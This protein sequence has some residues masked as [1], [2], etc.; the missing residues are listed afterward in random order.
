MLAL[1][2]RKWVWLDF[3][4]NPIRYFNYPA[5][6]AIEVLEPVYEVDWDDYEECLL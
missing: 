4:G 1:R 2:S 6:G 5:T 3:D